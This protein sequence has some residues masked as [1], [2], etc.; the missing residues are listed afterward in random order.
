MQLI[1]QNSVLVVSQDGPPNPKNLKADASSTS[2]ELWL[3]VAIP[4]AAPNMSNSMN[5]EL[6]LVGRQ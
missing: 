4:A 5:L 1:I 6:K 2:E 3:F